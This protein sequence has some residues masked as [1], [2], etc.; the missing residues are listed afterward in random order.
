[1]GA[2][3]EIVA[4]I[5]AK[6]AEIAPLKLTV[7]HL[8]QLAGEEPRYQVDGSGH[9]G[10]P[11]PKRNILNWRSDQFFNRPLAQCVTEYLVAREEAGGGLERAASVDEI[12]EALAK[13]GFR[14]EAAGSEE[15]IKRS[16]KIS[17]TKN[18]AQF[19]KV[20]ENLYGLKKWYGTPRVRKPNGKNNDDAEPASEGSTEGS[21][22]SQQVE[23]N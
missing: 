13:G 16:I 4:Q 19:A 20:S 5:E 18:T 22:E 10:V 21:T 23:N 3:D 1:M 2:I 9:A 15:N 7:N 8:C 12:Y 14:F 17:L 11:Q 6:E